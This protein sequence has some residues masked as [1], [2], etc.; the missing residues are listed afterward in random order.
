MYLVREPAKGRPE[1]LLGEKLR[2]FGA[3]M[4]MGPGGHVEPGE[5]WL[6]AAIRET[7]EESGLQ[8][9]PADAAHVATLSYVFPAKPHLD[10]EVQVFLTD[11]WSGQLQRSSELDP[12]WFSIDE[13]PFDRM[14]D[15][16][17]Y[18]LPRVLAGSRLVAEFTFDDDSIKVARHRVDAL[19]T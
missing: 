8:V 17:R 1:V 3:G 11:T 2:G 10:A 15:D 16:E 13:I 6:E 4:I 14:W 19:G 5:S 12:R 18:W 9:A 7:E